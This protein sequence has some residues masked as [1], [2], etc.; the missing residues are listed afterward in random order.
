MEKTV[1][2]SLNKDLVLGS[3]AWKYRTVSA[4]CRKAGISR[5][6]FYAILNRIYVSKDSVAVRKLKDDLDLNENL[7]W[8][9]EDYY[10]FD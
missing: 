7:L 9:R 4:Y 5:V 8:V 2:W 1:K 6:R 10:E 3:I